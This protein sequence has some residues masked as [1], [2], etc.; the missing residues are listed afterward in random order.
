MKLIST[1]SD[2]PVV[3]KVT[4]SLHMTITWIQKKTKQ[5]DWAT[6]LD[7][8]IAR[9]VESTSRVARLRSEKGEITTV[10]AKY[11]DEV[12]K[13]WAKPGGLPARNETR[14]GG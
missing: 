5:G 13:R 12:D 8:V 2:L 14:W 10:G 11:K 3:N 4:P 9:V 6:R 7:Y 1:Y